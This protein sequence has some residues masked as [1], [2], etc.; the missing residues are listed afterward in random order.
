[1]DCV[2]ET[3]R[4]IFTLVFHEMAQADQLIFYEKEWENKSKE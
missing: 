2:Y 1:L 4:N 3:S